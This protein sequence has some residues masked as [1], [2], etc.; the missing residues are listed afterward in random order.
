[1]RLRQEIRAVVFALLGLQV[2]TAAAAVTL[3]VRTGPVVEQILAENDYSLAAVE[4][5][6]HAL[7]RSGPDQPLDPEIRSRFEAALD[8]A[9]ANITE[10]PEV[11]HVDALEQSVAGLEVGDAEAR[12]RA[13]RAL[14][15]LASI[16][17]SSMLRTDE[18]A[19]R[20]ATAGAWAAVVLSGLTLLLGAMVLRRA[21]AQLEQPIEHLH[22]SAESVLRGEA[23]VRCP[24]RRMPV[25]LSQVAAALNQLLDAKRPPGDARGE[26]D[27]RLLLAL[28]DAQPVAT[29]LRDAGGVVLAANQR[30]LE[31]LES[32][33]RGGEVSPLSGGIELVRWPEG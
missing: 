14:A 31:H 6:L 13:L 33:D 8:R 1:M 11:A 22:R 15:E 24:D 19:Q 5:M 25:E 18:R 2:V 29:A 20:L 7:A 16:N 9:R 23:L 12:D 17:R 3:L 4:A 21:R 28:L 32:A 30:A 27:R 10:Q 26:R